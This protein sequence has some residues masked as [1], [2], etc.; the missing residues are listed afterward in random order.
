[1][2]AVQR[3]H[4]PRR[5][6]RPQRRRHRPDHPE[7]LA[8]ARRAHRL[9]RGT[10]LGVARDA[11]TSCST[12]SATTGAKI[13]VAGPNFGTRL[14]ARARGVGARGL[15]LP[16]RDLAALRRHLPQQLP[17]DR[18]RAGRAA[19]GRRDAH[20]AQRSRTTRR[21]RSSIDVVDR[22]V[23]VP[24]ID[25]DEPFEL[26]D[27]T[28]P[29]PAATASTTSA[30]RSSAATRSASYEAARPAWTAEGAHL[31]APSSA[32]SADRGAAHPILV[33]HAW[34]TAPPRGP[35]L[36]APPGVV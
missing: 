5:A 21:S 14:V 6:A 15:R 3:D 9:R 16:G 22:R 19:A 11:P 18:S 2:E 20:H 24:A 10:V 34:T 32:K 17:E 35:R 33:P 31:L 4:R 36:P 25:L 29:P 26:D 12:R 28:P 30:S 13:L 23:A 8:E 7:R 27:F 1:M